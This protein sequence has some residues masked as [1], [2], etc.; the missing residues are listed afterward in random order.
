MDKKI[1][2]YVSTNGDVVTSYNEDEINRPSHYAEDR[3]FEVI[4]VIEDFS[5]HWP[6]DIRYHLGN[7]TK[8]VARCN[9]KG[10][11]PAR[12]LKKARWY[13]DRAIGVLDGRG[14]PSE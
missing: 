10:N 12:D 6:S 4:D 11:D 5:R 7:V 2:A 13:I 9:K 8:Y 14:K 3:R 1:D